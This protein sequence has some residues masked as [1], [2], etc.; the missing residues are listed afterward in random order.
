MSQA[1][2]N[3]RHASAHG[4]AR[5]RHHAPRD[6]TELRIVGDPAVRHDGA[7]HCAETRREANEFF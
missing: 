5:R 3:L 6:F 4:A 2:P 1:S 7:A